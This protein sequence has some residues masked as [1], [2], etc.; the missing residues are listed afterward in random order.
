MILFE[1]AF[2]ATLP[3]LA[4]RLTGA[5]VQTWT[6]D[7]VP[8]RRAAEAAFAARGLR[9]QCH[10][11]YKPLVCAFRD[12]VIDTEGLAGVDITYPRH[13]HADP[14]RF[15]LES[16]PLAAM[17]P[18]VAFTFL[19]GAET[20]AL[21]AYDLRLRYHSG[22]L[23]TAQV[24]APNRAHPDYSG[25]LALSPCG[26]LVADGQA[27]PLMTD[28]EQLFHQTM[29]A[30]ARADWGTEPFFQELNIAVTLPA[31]DED[32]GY[33]DEALSL[34]EALHE[35]LYFS[36]LE[37]FG[38]LSGREAGDRLLQPGQ[39]VP[40]IRRGP[41]PGVRV[42]TRPYDRSPAPDHRQDLE[43]AS[44]PLSPAQI[45]AELA[46]LG[47][48]PFA[49]RSVAGRRIKAISVRG[50]DRGVII[51]AGQHANETTAP[52]GTL[53][54][55]RRLLARAGAHF[56]LCPLE[57]PDGYALHQRLIRD[58]PRHMHH[59]ARYT[60]LGDD[61]EYRAGPALF[62]Q[63]I[64][65][66]AE[67]HVPALLHLNLHGY[68]A[69]EWT[70]PLSGYVPRGFAT[71]TIPKGFFLIMRHHPGWD[72][73]ARRL[74]ADVTTRLDDVPGLRAANDAQIALYEQHAGPSGFEILN[75][76]PVLIAPDDRHRVPMT[77]ITEYPDETIYDDAFRAGHRAQMA[78][79]IA[80]YE[81]LQ[82]LPA[83][84]LPTN[85]RPAV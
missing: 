8:T 24:L 73:P 82:S 68:P 34:A 55:A 72:V 21:P 38:A 53:R 23:V 59:A 83:G 41:R 44:R 79:V 45:A 62:E 46:A 32:L 1:Q 84:L 70:R 43:T 76:F 74:M 47:G 81:A 9:A 50:G 28:Y 67:A 65:H 2:A 14:R 5:Q 75:G 40:E 36:A 85:T 13:P 49:A 19:E 48:T 10:S 52:V 57:N 56:T 42:Q 61:M 11:A 80:A 6:F 29:Q 27:S 12:G 16:Y 54:A 51:S 18:D 64:R 7:D 17:F 37:F 30:L 58:N 31:R 26:W 3:D 25:N 20:D 60:A 66:A 33:S 63:E 35:D 22:Q 15:L 71:W 39:I 77:L 69:H 4:A 78:A